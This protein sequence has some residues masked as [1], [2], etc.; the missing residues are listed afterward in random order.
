[1]DLQK[2]L[3]VGAPDDMGDCGGG[4]GDLPLNRQENIYLVKDDQVFTTFR[5]RLDVSS[6]TARARQK[7]R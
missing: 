3:L 4:S 6:A 2:R 7:V 1:M 5:V